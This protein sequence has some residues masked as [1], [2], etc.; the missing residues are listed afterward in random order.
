MLLPKFNCSRNEISAWILILSNL[1]CHCS[2]C[3]VANSVACRQQKKSEDSVACRCIWIRYC[4][5]R[6]I[7]P[8]ACFPPAW[9]FQRTFFLW[10][11]WSFLVLAFRRLIWRWTHGCPVGTKASLILFLWDCFDRKGRRGCKA[12]TVIYV[13]VPACSIGMSVQSNIVLGNDPTNINY[14]KCTLSFV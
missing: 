10:C 1:F 13:H 9:T 6:V 5:S 3:P 12:L 11:N 8:F 4:G 7:W 14:G 2:S